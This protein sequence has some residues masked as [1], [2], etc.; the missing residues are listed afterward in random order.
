[1]RPR[2]EIER[3]VKLVVETTGSI[4]NAQLLEILLDIRDILNRI[5]RDQPLGN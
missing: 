5:E 3:D 4:Q 1:M 2:P